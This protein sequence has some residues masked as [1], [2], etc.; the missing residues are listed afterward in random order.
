MNDRI[1]EDAGAVSVVYG[2]AAGL[3]GGG[4]QF[5][6]QRGLVGSDS[7]TSDLFGYTLATG[8]F[9]G[10]GQGE[11]VI[12]DYTSPGHAYIFHGPVSGAYSY[13][14]DASSITGDG[15]YLGTGLWIADRV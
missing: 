4:N 10:D 1:A 2:T 12:T 3:D 13:S 11:V 8:D 5:W 9:D 15:D 14:T 7:E 6:T